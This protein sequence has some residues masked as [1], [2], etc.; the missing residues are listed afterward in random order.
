MAYD[1]NQNESALP[2]PNNNSKKSIDFLPKFFRTE[3]NRKFL[4]GTLDQLISDGTAEKVDGYVGRKFTKGYSLSDNYIPEINKQREDYQLEPSV[5]LRD[6]L[7]N[8]DFVKDYKDYINTL[9]YFGSDVSNHDKLNTVNSYSWNPHIDFDK[10]TNFREYYW[11]PTGPL[12]VPLKGQAREITST[13]A[14]TLEDQG[15]NI[16][17]VFND[18]FTRNP[19]LKLYRGQTYRFDID[20]PG[21]PIAFSISR[22]FIPGLALL[23]AGKE[24]VRSSGLF[25]AE[26]YGNEY[27]IGDFVV[28]PD[29]GSVSFEADENVST[30]YNDG[31]SKFNDAGDE[32][33]V[34]YIEKGTIE[35]TIPTNAP[36][37]L[38]YIS[39]NDINTSGQIR[40]YDVEENTF[41]NI[42]NDILGKK[43][44]TSS[45]GIE[46]TNGLKVEFP[47]TVIPEKYSTGKW[48]VEG[49]GSAITLI[50][51]SD[52]TIPSTYT[53][54][55]QTPFDTEAFDTMPFSTA[56]NFP[57]QK[58]YLLINRAA[59]DKNPWSRNN[60]WFHKQVVLQS[61]EYNG[62]PENLDDNFRA[63]RPIIEFEA[64]LKL[65]NNGTFAKADVDLVDDFTTDVFSTI[66][67]QLGYI[68][69]SVEIAEGMRILFTKDN[70]VLVS[71]KI[72]EVNFVTIGQDRIINLIEVADSLPLDLETVFVKN[73][74]KYSG[75]TLHYHNLNWTL[76]QDKTSLNQAPLF[77]L[78]CPEG[79]A[80]SD[81]SVFESSNFYGTKIFSYKLGEGIT[82]TELGFPLAYRNISNAG[83]ILFEFNLLTD[84][85]SYQENDELISINVATANL[86]KYKNRDTFE[87]VNGWNST[88]SRF[89][90][91]VIK[92]IVVDSNNTNNFKID[93]YN[94]PH[95]LEDLKVHVYV[96]NTLQF[97]NKNYI[98][99]KSRNSVI[100]NFV[101][102]LA[103]DD[104]LEIKTHSQEAKNQNGY[105][106][107]PISLERNPLNED[108]TE[109]TL[110]EVYDHVDSMIEDI[111]TF[112]GVYPGNSNLRDAGK[113]NQFGK[114]FVKH[115]AGL[116]NAIYQITNKKYN[117]LKAVEYSNKEYTKFKKIFID[118]ATN[119]GYDGTTNKHVDRILK[120]IN[121]DKSKS[122]PFYFSDML[123][124]GNGNRIEYN[125]IDKEINIFPLTQSFKL[126]DFTPQSLIAYIN[127]TM[128]V[129]GRDYNFN[130]DGFIEITADKENGDTIEIYEY[131]S[132]D[133]SFIAPTPSKLGLY[134]TWNPEIVLDDTGSESVDILI[135]GPF[136]V[137]GE[138]DTG[139]K[140]NLHGWFH[141]V[142]TSKNSA[143][144]SDIAEG[145]TGN[146]NSIWFKG[147][148]TQFYV[149]E[150]NSTLAGN[151]N[152]NIELYPIGIP[153]IKGHDGSQVACYK[154][155]RDGLLLDLEKRIF[156]N[157]KINYDD[158]EFDLYNFT[159]GAFRGFKNNIDS[160]NSI[161]L[162]DFITWQSSLKGD[163]SDNSFY[164]RNNGFTFN[165]K[166]S[167]G[168]N[169]SQIP[170]FWR[171]IYKQAF[172]TDQ[173]HSH[174]WEMLGLQ[175]KPTWW[176]TVYG[177]APY[178][179]NNLL[180]WEDLEK[181]K[182]A[183]PNNTRIDK[184]FAR[185]GLT[186]FIPVDKIGKLVP[187]VKTNY[188]EGF[189]QRFA[190]SAFE[191][192][193]YSPIE[194]SWRKSSE[195]PFSILKSMLLLNPAETIGKGFDLSR[196]T[197]NLAGQYVY[198]DT[199]NSIKNTDIIFPNTYADDQRNITCGLIN[200]TY[201]L[202][203]SDILKVYTD[204][205]NEI[206]NLQV[207]LSF[208][209]G[210]FSDKN[211]LN[212]VLESK[213]PNRD[214]GSSGIF[215]PQ[216][217]YNLVYNVSSPIDN[218]IYSG[219]IIEKT[220]SG[221]KI[222]GYNQKNSYF[223]Y[224]S[225]LF[226]STNFIVTV[227]GIS[228][229]Y[230]NWSGLTPYKKDQIVFQLN[231]YYRVTQDFT[232]SELFDT[233]FL[234]KLPALPSIGGR[235]AEF[236]KTFDT[237]NTKKLAYGTI[238]GNIQEV[239]SFLL[240]YGKYLETQGF[241]F[242]DV[243]D[244][245]V[246][247]WSSVTKEFMFW[248]TQG[249]SN[250]TVISVS[251]SANQ[252]VFQ[253]DFAVV[254]DVFDS[255]YDTS[256][257]SSN[258]QLLDRNFNSILRDQNNFGIVIKDTD[259]G[260]YGAAL[261]IVQKE[262]V[263]VFDNNTIFNDVIYHPASGYRQERIKLNGY[264][265][266][267][268]NGSLNIPGFIYDNAVVKEFENYQDY[269]IGD[270]IKYKEYYYVAKQNVVGSATLDYNQWY[271]LNSKPVPDLVSN[272]DYRV[273]QF[274]DFYEVN[275][276]SFDDTLHDLSARLIGFQKRNYLSNLIVDDV[277]QLKF[278]K[279]F[280]QEKGTKNSLSKLFEPLSAQGEESLEFFEEWAVRSGVYGASEKVKQIEIPLTDTKMI[281]SPQ[282]VLFT[283][284]LPADNFDNIYR[285]LP[286]DLLDKPLDYTSN[287][288]PRLQDTTEFIKSS[289]YVDEKDIDFEAASVD[290]LALGNVNVFK[291]GGYLHL[292]NQDNNDWTVYQHVETGLNA[293]QL[294]EADIL[295][296]QG[297]LIF[298]LQLDT[299]VGD[300]LQIGE[301]IAVRGADEYSFNGF[302]KIIDISL[303]K[304]AIKIPLS[305]DINGFINESLIVT[306]LRKVRIQN[307][308]EANTTVDQNIYENQKLWIDN[309]DSN[310]QV[311]QNQK[312]YS[313][314]HQYDNPSDWDSTQQKFTDSMA[315]TDDNR[316]VFVSSAG[317]DSGKVFIYKRSNEN[318]NLQLQ[319][320]LSFDEISDWKP[321]TEYRNGAR[322]RYDDKYYLLNL[323]L[324][325]DERYTS[326]ETFN[327][328]KWTEIDSPN[329][330]MDYFDQYGASIDVSSDGEYLVIGV[331]N[332]SGVKTKYLG[333]FNPDVEYLK[334]DV[335]KFRETFWQ[336]NLTVFPQ[337]GTQ[338]FSTFDS[339]IDL[340][341]RD[342]TD[343]TNLQLL[344]SGKFGLPTG[345]IDH[346][347]VRAP[348][349]MYIGTKGQI[350]DQPGDKVSLAWNSVS[351]AYPTL[352][353]YLPFDNQISEI[354]PEFLNQ[355]HEIIEKIDSILFVET[356]VSLPTVGQ[357]VE[358][359]TGSGEVFYVASYRDS[360]VIY[361]KNINGIIDITGEI[362]DLNNGNFIGF[363]SQESTYATTPSVGGFWYINTAEFDQ[364]GNLISGFTY[365]N[366]GR[367]LDIGRG[368]VYAD[369]R[370]SSNDD[371]TRP[372]VYYNIQSTVSD[373]GNFVL[374]KNRVSFLTNLS[375]RGDIADEES[376]LWAV[377]VGKSYSDLLDNIGALVGPGNENN[378]TL[379]LK[380]NETQAFIDDVNSKGYNINE[381]NNENK[382]YDIWDGYIDFEF[383]EFDFV[384]EPFE[385]VVGDVIQDVQFPRDGQGGLALT[386][387]STSTAQIV[388][389][390]K[391]FNSVRVYLKVLSGSWTQLNNIGKFQIR[392][393]AN[394][395][396]RGSG[397]VDRVMGTVEDVDNSI[398]L[399]TDKVG[400]LIVFEKNSQD[401]TDVFIA[402]DNA[403][404]LESEYYFFDETI[405]GGINRLSNAPNSLN[406]D[407]S[408]VYNIPANI[409][410]TS[411][412]LSNEGAVIIY[413]R[414]P[415]GLYEFDYVLTSQYK[416]NERNFGDQVKIRK[417]GNTYH[418]LVGSKGDLNSSTRFDPGSIEVF[419][420]GPTD[421][422]RF[423]G[424]YQS[425]VYQRGDIVLYKDNFYVANKDTDEGIQ[426]NILDSVVWNNISWKYGVDENYRGNWDNT[427]GY[428][429]GSIVLYNNMFYAAKT[430]I[431]AGTEFT[432]NL[433]EQISS[434]IDYLGYLPN[435]TGNNL[436]GEDVF[437]PNENIIEF[438][439]SFDVSKNGEILVVTALLE[440]TD[441][442]SNKKIAIYR[443]EDS[444]YKLYETIS[445]PLSGFELQDHDLDK[446]ETDVDGNWVYR[447]TAG[448]IATPSTGTRTLNPNA[449][450]DVFVDKT[451]WAHKVAISPDGTQIVI[452][453]LNDNTRKY[454]QGLVL[455]YTQNNGSFTSQEPQFLYSPQGEIAEN[456]GYEIGFTDETLL[457]TSLN[458]DQKIPTRFDTYENRLTG[459]LLDTNSEER[460]ETT[461]DLGFTE[462]RNVGIDTGVV[463]VYENLYNSYIYSEQFKFDSTTAEFGKNLLAKN[464]HVYV[465]IPFYNL[466]TEKGILVDYRKPKGKKAWNE[467]KQIV[468]PV[469]LELIEGAYLYNTKENRIV[470]YVD[471]IDPIQGKIA[472]IAET[473]ITYKTSSDPAYYNVGS[474]LEREVDP[475]QTWFDDHVGQVWW[476]ISTA[477][478]DYPYQ[479]TILEQ[480]N[481]WSKLTEGAS[482][483]VY[484]W[485][486]TDY[487]PSQYSKLADTE[488][489]IKIGIS[490]Q[491]IYGD[492]KFSSKLTYDE[493]ARVFSTKY[494]FWVKNKRT[495]PEIKNRTI[496]IFD[497]ESL[498]RTPRETGYRYISFTGQN[499]MIL[500]NFDNL[501]LSNDIVLNVKYKSN[502]TKD[503]NEHVEFKLL[504]EGDSNS[505]LDLDIERKW[506]DSLIGF[507]TNNRPVPD[508]SLPKRQKYGILNQPRQTMFVN[509]AEA[510]KQTIER[511]NFKFEEL[512]I[513]DDYDISDLLLTDE[514]PSIVSREY[515]TT[516]D[517]FEELQF[518][519]TNNVA[520]AKLQPVI[521]NGKIIRI[522]VISSGR[523]YKV[524][525]SIELRGKGTGAQIELVIN[526]L[527]N[528]TGATII[529]QGS[530]YGPDTSITVRKFSVLVKSDSTANSIWSVY[531]YNEIQKNWFRRLSQGFDVTK[532]WDYKD[533]YA[534]GYNQFT[535]INY[536]IDASYQL[537]TINPEFNSIIKIKN[538]GGSGWL[539]LKR[540][541]SSNSEDY[542]VD[543]ETIGREKGTI[544]LL[545]T[546]YDNVTTTVGYD[547]RSF[548]SVLFDNNPS[549]ELR[550]IFETL[551][552]KIFVNDLAYEYTNLFFCGLR[553]A[554]AE[555]PTLDWAFKT[556]FIKIN[557]NVG[558]LDQP[559]T[560]RNDN[561]SYFRDYV[562]EVKPY[563][564]KIRE[565]VTRHNRLEPTNTAVT[566]FDAGPYY[567]DVTKQI[568]A[569]KSTIQEDK[570]I[571]VDT[572]LDEYPRKFFTD[573]IGA[574][575]L[576]IKI[577]NAGS[578][579]IFPPKVI[580]EDNNSKAEA[581]AFIGYGKVTKIIVR[582]PGGMFITPPKITLEGSQTDDGEIATAF[583]ILGK[584]LIRT[585][586]IKV[587]F[588]RVSGDYF[589]ED[590]FLSE[591]FTSSG[592]D[593]NFDLKWPLDLN[594]NK[595]K[596]FVNDQ[597][598]LRS[599]YV[600]S[601]VEK[602][603]DY[604]YEQ[605][606]I[607]FATPPAS[608][609]AIRVE[610]YKPLSLL[611]A[612]DRIKFAYN[613]TNN[614]FGKDLN[615]LMTGIDYGGVEVKSFD[616]GGPSGWDSQPWYTDAWDIYENTFEDEI[617]ISDGSTI[618]VELRAPLE[619]D[620][621][622]NLYRNGVRIDDPKFDE[623]AATNS[624]AI[625]N[626]IIGDGNTTIIETQNLGIALNDG[627]VLVVRKITSDGS[628]APDLDSYDSALQGGDLAYTTA[629]GINAEEIITDGDLFVST[630]RAKTEELVPGSVFDTLDLKVF[631][632]KSGS[633]GLITC[634]NF[635]TRSTGSFTYNFDI[636]PGT[637][638]SILVKYDGKLLDK[639]EFNVNWP[640][641][642]LTVD[643]E[644]RKT[645]SIIL[646]ED[647]TSTNIIDSG[648]L[649]ITEQEQY[650]FVIDYEYTDKTALS[651]TLNGDIQDISIFDYSTIVEGDNRLAF[652]LTDPATLG[653]TL[654]YT[655]LS[656]N[657]TV[658]YSQI[659]TDEFVATGSQEVFTLG[660]A[661]FYALPTE[662]NTVVRVDQKVLNSGYSKNFVI[663]ENNQ[664]EYQLELF[665]QPAGSL[666]AETML[667][668]LNGQQIFTPTEW[669][670]DISN[671]SIIL[672]DE[673]GQPGDTIEVYNIAESEYIISGNQITLKDTPA[674]NANIYVTQFS[675][676]NLKE[677]EKIQYDIVKREA[678]ITD[679]ELST[680]FRLTAGEIQLRAPAID[681]QYVWVNKNGELLTPSVDYFITDD[682][683]RLRLETIP[684][685][686]DTIEIIHFT[687][688]LTVEGFAY[689]QFKDILNRT[690]YKRLDA[691]STVLVEDLAYNDLR[692]EVKNGEDLPMPDKG[693]NLP[694][695][696]FIN[697]ERI[698]YF[699]KEENTLRQIRRGTLGTGVPEIHI[700]GQKVFNQNKDK[701]VPY[702]DQNLVANLIADGASTTFT[703]GYNIDS[704]NEI[705]VFAAGKRLRKNEIAVFDQ[706]K[707]LTSP[708]GDIILPAEFSVDTENNTITLLDT[709]QENS[710]VTIIKRQGQVWTKDNEMLGNS[711][712]SIARF[713]RAGTY[714]QP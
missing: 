332:A 170:G 78:C 207:N 167:N 374:N 620:V 700:T 69:D 234:A 233:E 9:K 431:A 305:N 281:E 33:A 152:L 327:S 151:D 140:K 549:R 509:R 616:F 433:W 448:E 259:L 697:G 280:I 108:V 479:G 38:F 558:D 5:T 635:R 138:V 523:G 126:S 648:E 367:Y 11:L 514:T 547:N 182:I 626:S 432:E 346:I 208:R 195:Y 211:K 528:V 460:T 396:I 452:S 370:P 375:Y 312:V 708:A 660:Q 360:A 434:S 319:Q 19:T 145:G 485:V 288:F 255:F 263:V 532:Y 257:V 174:P 292:T 405:E 594:K 439:K 221:F 562:E 678:L 153:V 222:S 493:V 158:N 171:G 584:S 686:N 394:E 130:T 471:Y 227:G 120:D 225:P 66:Q 137:Y 529:S 206:Q 473:N 146:V 236:Y 351:Y 397:D 503:S 329:G 226:G 168:I 308:S 6:N 210:S 606:N 299:W 389:Y 676:H 191:F 408:Q 662:H 465:G 79:T 238:L 476:N 197:K 440:S 580:I 595:I 27:D 228:E 526:S 278:Y 515:D 248:T 454:K 80:Y 169:G 317:D 133:G 154:D 284:N 487:L 654:N 176:N 546:L 404:I 543:Y 223:N 530:G 358:T 474:T 365:A 157:I 31:I 290:D 297:R 175:K 593:A 314:L 711:Q 36:N 644:A 613:P 224:Y 585:P 274:N 695:I 538:I 243:T 135:S 113:I 178:T 276:A 155:F 201:N 3:A 693:K 598:M 92:N 315:A 412:G 611:D 618:A 136:K 180:L 649:L 47:G 684:N 459:Y 525:P 220:S 56:N 467:Y 161:L 553:Y 128:L 551:R 68:I 570:L 441:S 51:E 100:I 468:S 103:V 302:Y 337:I 517:T 634:K 516:V 647:T 597:E 415:N 95:L 125:V 159:G 17:Y 623:D 481:T 491:P 592:I 185:P 552:D 659:I 72:F 35:F 437:D 264:K 428:A 301:M 677:I 602:V 573:N 550:I 309:I 651:V 458:G 361:L 572:V 502:P 444:K 673:Y 89:K 501:I 707:A 652:R 599:T 73:G 48:Y 118:T 348:L 382:L 378:K 307:A 1:D 86:R 102:D 88:P 183:D 391:Q 203:A 347:L 687:A 218:F 560:F 591:T 81:N 353:E 610:Y 65:F 7:E 339:Y 134:P 258:G 313:F 494:Y 596:V 619:E 111:Q 99:T 40:I 681:A 298:E 399:G 355:E 658:N 330:Y 639:S 425:T 267:E 642:Q 661:P 306:K 127:G 376:N 601:N 271:L 362:F 352:D 710:R 75:K 488:K 564:S 533:W 50:S 124:Y 531:G 694:G 93:V 184:R 424:E 98:I 193:D 555:Q 141:P 310:W 578:G 42:K 325:P 213:T 109:F 614:M 250:G 114:R 22:T 181:G 4:Q 163:Y 60:R 96:N 273:A 579:Y 177:P 568:E 416:Q 587:K 429:I 326:E 62:L 230:S 496:S 131:N 53:D 640:A 162:T 709:P 513:V 542:S 566:D 381:L 156:N 251:P 699:V 504:S 527:G 242:D 688:N 385:P 470:S 204:Y 123:G 296:S 612:A 87:Y 576:E 462:F 417:F 413:R 664:R 406:K 646:Q 556:S 246:N 149:P 295:D 569:I 633:Q 582:N 369:T 324:Q 519:S 247:D 70:D 690:H 704:I 187:P 265:A 377:R 237:I 254:D 410:G 411:S 609:A 477:R 451:N 430:N 129:H 232:S 269:K 94:K 13:Y 586:S 14:V 605:G 380:F 442:T 335:V 107:L 423:K 363:Y 583:A 478:F 565:F 45:N 436:L 119:L 164:D 147:L 240:G 650:D 304:I 604:T 495:I 667:V 438:S 621:V 475:D 638:D 506:F 349:D 518:V 285:V 617:F 627:D 539:L 672:G 303:N 279:G 545:S 469:N 18:G 261:P 277:S 447:D 500:N 401:P 683:M 653:Q 463:Y 534:P 705:E 266:A 350:G 713:L 20:T 575:I 12:S 28:T 84:N 235:S 216:E 607:L 343:S 497:I 29:A 345:N 625:V 536:E 194:S 443:K 524:P 202:V 603:E 165:Y 427:Y 706:N 666:D 574:Q 77:D 675:N 490:G 37:R 522:D 622:Y 685:E 217:N 115:E 209:L 54:N 421:N 712:N 173:P 456:F 464:N 336:A 16:A 445:A 567:N 328:F 275:T 58:D 554:V 418:L 387:K 384:G 189:I 521:S 482:I 212:F 407:W 44:Y 294:T 334:H 637:I 331:P 55:I 535:N 143:Q 239:V 472:G 49:V 692:I 483:D 200:F 701:T 398:I 286:S 90:Q 631:T 160:I 511:I 300:S 665:Q 142:F 507:D 498:I 668:F 67:G 121:N 657:E 76:A 106:E 82:D 83:D 581:E 340:T 260:L 426:L 400:K 122:Q 435:L 316:N 229:E 359:D 505:K 540:V 215:I 34:V 409:R 166:S 480:K 508:I 320:V 179:S 338:P 270:L 268:W 101:Q 641:K 10:F 356:Y 510:L 698:E 696:I 150:T 489:G 2:T 25:D 499:R 395:A 379:K 256:I 63:K 46:L 323:T 354:T 655:I 333:D 537:Q 419:T 110:G 341:S 132:T 241:T 453:V 97:K 318:A 32:I 30:L 41:L 172:D 636:L 23:V 703:I 205:Q 144:Q 366:N 74:N 679:T 59:Q 663:P 321:F 624:Y 608:N 104:I 262:H 61:F 600:A 287:V 512:L 484:E 414:Q 422:D 342:D 559:A 291:L 71:G 253:Q 105:Y 390:R 643:V 402:V 245:V 492:S 632:R 383:T 52:L 214:I 186:T 139:E 702:K 43:Y 91:Y 455:V 393:L 231:T 520:Q 671:S 372:F 457:I 461:F 386:S 252:L 196:S 112:E 689:R 629:A 630:S 293:T 371:V 589:V 691:H 8:I 669:R 557:H 85:F 628:V 373:I 588:D 117:L 116:V 403:E 561:L 577:K 57:L 311:I 15:D 450:P 26:L 364:Q 446:F 420:H 272:F 674:N 198:K 680:Y 192:G 388:S 656:D 39:Q 21:H 449:T 368:L 682:K 714:E 190:D 148:T 289:G 563:S 544:T 188:I 199:Q 24:G 571:K 670:L 392:R 64:G 249:W 344:V 486:E 466:E 615:Q 322:I 548:D 219:V 357:I 282:P 590:L 244:E 541:G 645:L 283:D